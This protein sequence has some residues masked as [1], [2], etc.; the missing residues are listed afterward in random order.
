M[1]GMV[2]NLSFGDREN[3]GNRRRDAPLV[4]RSREG[5]DPSDGFGANVK[6]RRFKRRRKLGA[7]DGIGEEGVGKVKGVEEGGTLEFRGESFVEGKGG[8]GLRGEEVSIKEEGIGARG[9]SGGG[10]VHFLKGFFDLGIELHFRE[11]FSITGEVLGD[12]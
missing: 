11:S 5:V 3:G 10:E 9:D 8:E 6:T 4:F 12:I 2:S 7:S 1:F